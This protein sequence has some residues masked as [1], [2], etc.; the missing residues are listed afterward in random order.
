VFSLVACL[1]RLADAAANA[2]I[3]AL[4]AA[5]A[6]GIA[7]ANDEPAARDDVTCNAELPSDATSD[8]GAAIAPTLGATTVLRGATLMIPL[9]PIK[10]VSDPLDKR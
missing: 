6:I 7:L 2:E 3:N 9:V 1:A 5:P 4:N 8:I 10:E